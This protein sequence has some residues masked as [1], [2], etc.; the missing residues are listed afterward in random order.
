MLKKTALKFQSDTLSCDACPMLVGLINWFNAGF[1]VVDLNYNIVFANQY[2]LVLWKKKIEEIRGK[3]LFSAGK[4]FFDL[5]KMR[6][7]FSVVMR[8]KSVQADYWVSSKKQ[9]EVDIFVYP[10]F[11]MSENVIGYVVM[12]RTAA[13][14]SDLLFSDYK[15]DIFIRYIFG[16][17]NEGAT[18]IDNNGC[19]EYANQR[20]YDLLGYRSEELV[21]RHWTY[22]CDENYLY[23]E[24]NRKILKGGYVDRGVFKYNIK[25]KHKNGRKIPVF[26]AVSKNVDRDLDIKSIGVITDISDKLKLES[27]FQKMNSLNKR[28][29]E[30][31]AT[32]IITLDKNLKVSSINNQVEVLFGKKINMVRGL[33]L[34]DAFPNIAIL[35]EWSNWVIRTLRPYHVDRYKLAEPIDNKMLFINVRINPFFE[36]DGLVSGVVCAFDDVSMS[37]KLEEQIEISY[38]NL[39]IAHN[40]LSLLLKRQTDF[41]AD[42]SHELRTPLTVISG[43]VEVVLQDRKTDKKE[44]V[45]VLKL[46]ENESRRMKRM[47]EDLTMLTKLESGQIGLRYSEFWVEDLIEDMMRKLK[48]IDHSGKMVKFTK[49]ENL[50]VVADLEKTQALLW[51]IIENSLK[52]TKANGLIV[53]RIYRSAKK[54][55]ELVIEVADNGIGIPKEQIDFI[56]DRFYR[57][58]KSRSRVRGGSGLGLAICKWIATAHKGEI[59]AKSVLG[60]GSTFIVRMPVLKN[61]IK[62]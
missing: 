57:V 43:N 44:Y 55:R 59:K 39:E 5:E 62:D 22:W 26:L 27:D 38:R 60:K 12:S 48:Y 42:V 24:K 37:A 6:D 30:T 40:K 10:F 25:L 7:L 54:R 23:E 13:K 8:K 1:L 2:F 3:N 15:I 29:L 46:V 18:V 11:D 17:M 32:G 19:L 61:V 35:A 14:I 33:D 31:I 41:L 51:N 50:L 36:Q 47:V 20:F 45:S 28:V 58:D 9:N 56:F 4:G 49:V 34:R 52:Y 53:V 16:V 21:G